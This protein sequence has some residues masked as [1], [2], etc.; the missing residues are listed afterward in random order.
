MLVKY[1]TNEIH[2][3]Y[4]TLT[5][6]LTDILATKDFKKLRRACY[7]EIQAPTSTLPKSLIQEL[8]PTK[9]VDD[10]LN[11]LAISPYWNWFDTRL[12]QALVNASGSPEAEAM[13][14]QFKQI[15]YARKVSEVLSC[16]IVLPL[17]DS[18]SFKEK[19][20]KDPKE[21]TLLDLLQHKHT[22]EYEVMDVGEN[23]IILSCIR[24]GCVE[25]IWQIPL[26]L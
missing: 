7:Q 8:K 4:Q 20:N 19:F 16:V 12:L 24:T 25:L 22:L 26:D 18:I 2:T 5:G 15:H 9:S 1:S 13:L 3:A 23:K 10:M 6:K 21:L 14:E 11:V 17:K